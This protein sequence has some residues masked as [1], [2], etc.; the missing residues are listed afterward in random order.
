M[1]KIIRKIKSS[2]G[3]KYEM[4]CVVCKKRF[5]VNAY[6]ID[7][8]KNRGKYC[9]IKCYHSDPEVIEKFKKSAGF[10]KG[11]PP[12]NKGLTKETDERIKKCSEKMMGKNHHNWKGG[13]VKTTGGYIKIKM[14]E[15]PD[16][17][18]EGYVLEH[19]L[20]MEKKI[21]RRLNV[22]EEVHHKNGIK[23]D[24]RIENLELVIKKKHFG[25]VECPYCRKKFKIK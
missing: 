20:I 16:A 2:R 14:R 13:K 11:K 8:D 4:E 3:H 5:F 15:H 12:W 25:E 24:N 22:W 18:A 23:S 17:T 10:R 19:R 9:S 6:K 21:G 1:R 7:K